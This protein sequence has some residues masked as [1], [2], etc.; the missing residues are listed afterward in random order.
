[1][2]LRNQ[3]NNQIFAYLDVNNK[4]NI[5]FEP[6]TYKMCDTSKKY[7]SELHVFGEKISTFKAE[8]KKL[9]NKYE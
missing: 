1:M 6:G 7:S 4:S 2:R 8:V 9:V 3:E 5:K